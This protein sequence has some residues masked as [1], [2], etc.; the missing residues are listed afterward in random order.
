MPRSCFNRSDC[1][2]IDHSACWASEESHE[3]FNLAVM[4]VKRWLFFSPLNGRQA[5]QSTRTQRRCSST[6]NPQSEFV[7]TGRESQ[8][9]SWKLS[10][11]YVMKQEMERKQSFTAIVSIARNAFFIWGF[12]RIKYIPAQLIPE[13]L[14]SV[15]SS[16]SG[17]PAYFFLLSFIHRVGKK[18][19]L[20]RVLSRFLHRAQYAIAARWA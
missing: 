20:W 15:D 4:N 18:L 12:L 5:K 9:D 7:D 1:L 16:S 2:F 10:D 14:D 17:V 13:G 6:E 11:V 19:L 8:N 3:S